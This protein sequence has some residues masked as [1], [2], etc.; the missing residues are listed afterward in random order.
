MLGLG[1]GI[2]KLS[3]VESGTQQ[4]CS[5]DLNGTNA[6]IDFG[7]VLNS[8]IAG[9]NHTFSVQRVVKRGSIGSNQDII[10]K[11]TGA[12]NL[13]QFRVLFDSSNQ[14]QVNFSN[15]GTAAGNTSNSTTAT[16]TNITAFYIITV[17]FDLIV[18]NFGGIKVYVNGSAVPF[19][20]P[21]KAFNGANTIYSGTAS[22]L[23]GATTSNAGIKSAF[24]DGLDND[25]AIYSDVLTAGEVSTRYNGGNILEP[26][27][28]GLVF[29]TPYNDDVWDG[30][31]YDV[32]D[33]IGA[34]NGVTVNVLENEKLCTTV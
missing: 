28:S 17:T 19:A 22:L 6:Y 18:G 23:F 3:R 10:G 12:G 34:N 20:D 24:F 15:D 4:F 30:S 8:T 29:H 25:G 9:T 13:R 7:N 2:N 11:W 27:S 5:Y 26:H 33:V 16:F 1:L 32:I 14:I 21:T 31:K